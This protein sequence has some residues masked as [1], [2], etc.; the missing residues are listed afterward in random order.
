M[1]SEKWERLYSVNRPIV[2]SSNVSYGGGCFMIEPM[3]ISSVFRTFTIMACCLYHSRSLLLNCCI[4]LVAQLSKIL[5]S[6]VSSMNL[7]VRRAD[8]SRQ[9]R[10]GRLEGRDTS[11][12][13]FQLPLGE[14]VPDF[15]RCRR[16]VKNAHDHRI[17]KL[18][19]P[20]SRSLTTSMCG[21]RVQ[22]PWRSR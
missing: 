21:P 20:Y 2:A 1:D 17:M 22:M 16:S 6:V 18:N 11:P 5:V 14:D 13:P 15:N 4:L 7:C 9:L 19:R 10:W 8:F 3:I 12:A